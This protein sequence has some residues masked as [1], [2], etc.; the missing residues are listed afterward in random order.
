[1]CSLAT[2]VGIEG[3]ER[4]RTDGLGPVADLP[5]APLGLGQRDVERATRR[6][7]QAMRD[8]RDRDA[9]R[10][11]DNDVDVVVG[12]AGCEEH[13][14]ERSGFA[15][16]QRG[17]PRIQPWLEPRC[18]VACRPDHVDDE[19][20]RGMGM[21]R[22]EGDERTHRHAIGQRG[23][24][25]R[26]HGN[27]CRW[28]VV[29]RP[30]TSPRVRV[31]EP[32]RAQ[33]IIRFEMPEDALPPDHRA[34]LLWRVVETLDL[35]RF[36]SDA[37]A[38]EGRQGRAVLSARMLLTLWLCAIS[39]GIGSAR[40][41]ARLIDTDDAF[42]WVVGDVSVGHTK[43]SEF[44]VLHGAALD[45]LFTD[46]LASLLHKGLVSLE[47]VAQD[48]TRVRASASAPS[49]RREASLVECREQAALHVKAVFA[50]ADDPTVTV[51][52]QRAREAAALDYQ[53]R[54]EE[55]LATVRAL[56]A[57]SEKDEPRASTT[58]ADARVMKMPDGGFRPG[59]N[60][61]LATAGSAMGGPRTIVGVRVTNVGSDMGS[62]TPMLADI[63]A[64][65]GQLPATLLA[66]ANHAKHACII[67][68]ARRGVEVLIAVPKRE[69]SASLEGV[70]PEIAT[71]RARMK[72]PEAKRAYRV[73][74]SLC[75]LVNAHL[76]AHHGIE[77]VLVRGLAKV[78][79][80][81]LLGALAN[82]I[83]AHATSLLA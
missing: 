78:T 19:D 20:G 26:G 76:K 48:G 58:D 45:Q 47:R 64:R 62:V 71:W 61:Q 23:V 15:F 34:R 10:M 2:D 11:T 79:C 39:R 55:A 6:S 59:Y 38:V 50:E 73:R 54:V 32:F 66:D 31:R 67:H 4:R 53:R 81:A 1:M 77:H 28:R 37:R 75:E 51:A 65:T 12:I 35:S 52:E 8:L 5:D 43:L 22:D 18:A 42:R 16:E 82:N 9:R 46:V 44:R 29:E 25:L 49:F 41:I 70:A 27:N 83:L 17:K 24:L 57:E 72:T 80:V 74:A 30:M 3:I 63:E 60:V 56:R 13:A 68:A 69:Q 36:T 33:G 7:L 40:E 21:P 14:V